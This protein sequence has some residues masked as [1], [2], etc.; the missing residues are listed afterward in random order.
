MEYPFKEA[1]I[2]AEQIGGATSSKELGI[3]FCLALKSD[4]VV[5]VGCDFGRSTL[6]ISRAA[7]E[8]YTI[9]N[10]S[11]QLDGP[12]YDHKAEFLR[13]KEKYNINVTLIEEDSVIAASKFE[14]IINLLFI[15]A[16]HNP[17][18]VEKDIKAWLPKVRGYIAFHDYYNVS[19]IPYSEKIDE[20][21]SKYERLH[22][23]DTLGVWKVG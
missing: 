8:F 23:H 22:H 15:D 20:L 6:I 16:D 17:E 21:M 4:V 9:D 12:Y 7:K 3:L 5:E 1:L 18:N 14:K 11:M 19:C 10:F 2:E 13:N